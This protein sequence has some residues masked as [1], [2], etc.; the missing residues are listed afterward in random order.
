MAYRA[1]E[2]HEHESAVPR[3]RGPG[4]FDREPERVFRRADSQRL[5]REIGR[6]IGAAL[7]HAAQA[8]DDP[9]RAA[10]L[11]DG[12]LRSIVELWFVGRAW[13][14]PPDVEA[15]EVIGR[16]DGELALRLRLALRAPH[17]AARLVQCRDLLERV[18][19]EDQGRYQID[20]GCRAR[21]CGD[22]HA[23]VHG[24]LRRR[25]RA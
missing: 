18:E 1:S 15:L 21:R 10:W 11:L 12:A 7:A 2:E 14:L 23:G 4:W 19:R 8:I 3:G 13:K 16:E 25:A 9:D 6:E 20:Q 24:A 22:K 5:A 17:V